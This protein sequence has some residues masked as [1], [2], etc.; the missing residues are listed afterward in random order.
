MRGRGAKV[1]SAGE[2]R[3]GGFLIPDHIPRAS[4]GPLSPQAGRG[5]GAIRLLLQL[6]L[7]NLDFLGQRHI[8]ADQAL[9]LT[10]RMQH[11]G[12]VAAAETPADF[13]Q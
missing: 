12:V 3:K 4:T 10:H 2:L 1:T 11:G 8:I 7:Q 9:D 6:T 13:R 5:G